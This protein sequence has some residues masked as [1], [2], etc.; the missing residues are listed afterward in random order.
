MILTQVISSPMGK[1]TLQATAQGLCYVGFHPKYAQTQGENEHLS[2]AAQQLEEYFAGKRQTFSV[3]LDVTGTPF[4]K[5]VWQVLRQVPYATTTT[6]G[7]MAKQLN[8]PK[9]VRAVGAA[10]GKNPISFIVP[11]HRI[12]GANGTLTGYAGGLA[13]KAWLLEHEQNVISK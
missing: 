7:W 12:I 3:S 1:V 5:A 10:N 8:N 6:Y 13:N 11:C 9:A 2:L 4:Q